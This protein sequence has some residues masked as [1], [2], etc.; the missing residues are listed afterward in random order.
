MPHKSIIILSSISNVQSYS[1]SKAKKIVL[2]NPK[3]NHQIGRWNQPI[4]MSSQV[5]SAERSDAADAEVSLMNED[6]LAAFVFSS[7]DCC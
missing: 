5:T 1:F 3:M 4:N 2:K 6:V 7:S